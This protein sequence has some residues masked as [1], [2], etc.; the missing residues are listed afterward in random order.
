MLV[1]FT[2]SNKKLK[3]TGWRPKFTSADAL[4]AAVG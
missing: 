3:T 1:D 4:R 2:G